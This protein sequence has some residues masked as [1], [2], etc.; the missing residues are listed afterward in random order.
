MNGYRVYLV[1]NDYIVICADSVQEMDG[2]TCF[3]KNG[4]VVA[5]FITVNIKGYSKL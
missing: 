3:T 4:E 1:A 5:V 2:R